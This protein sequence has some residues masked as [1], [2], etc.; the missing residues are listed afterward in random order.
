MCC[1]AGTCNEFVS[2]ICAYFIP[3]LGVFFRFGCGV[4][5]CICLLLTLC[6]YFPG[7]IYAVCVI[8]CE[9]PASGREPDVCGDPT[10]VCPES[11]EGYLSLPQ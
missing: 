2:C 9:S 5:F 7:V 11:G 1:G 10:K 3:P 8:G 4:E 6:G